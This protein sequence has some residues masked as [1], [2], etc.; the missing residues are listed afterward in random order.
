MDK[1]GRLEVEQLKVTSTTP[2]ADSGLYKIDETTMGVVGDLKF[3]HPKTGAMSSA[4]AVTSTSSGGVAKIVS[5]GSLKSG[6]PFVLCGSMSLVGGGGGAFTLSAAILSG[7]GVGLSGSPAFFYLPANAAGSGCVAGWY[8]GVFSGDTNGVVY[9]DMYSGGNPSNA[10]PAAPTPFVGAPA[11]T[12]VV[13]QVTTEVDAIYGH[14][15]QG[16]FIGRDTEL[17]WSY[18]CYGDA[19]GLKTYR[20][21]IGSN[22]ALY[23]LTSAAQ[24]VERVMVLTSSGSLSRQQASRSSSGVGVTGTSLSGDFLSIDFSV[25]Q[26]MKIT[27]QLGAAGGSMILGRFKVSIED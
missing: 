25:D 24:D 16:G 23:D 13:T 26:P 20:L 6:V 8:Y 21:K 4:L 11:V 27:M 15:I 7:L 10:I 19:A 1:L 18:K 3:R 2:P 22:T 5:S 9:A 17:T 12:T 14:T